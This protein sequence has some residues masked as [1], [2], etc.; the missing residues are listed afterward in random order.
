MVAAWFFTSYLFAS[1]LPAGFDPND[2]QTLGSPTDVEADAIAVMEQ[3]NARGAAA[4]R[5][6]RDCNERELEANFTATIRTDYAAAT[7]S[8]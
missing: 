1:P 7:D 8:V 3:V 6:A 5:R 4:Q 2:A